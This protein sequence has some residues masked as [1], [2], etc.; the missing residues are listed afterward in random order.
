MSNKYVKLFQ[1]P[2]LDFSNIKKDDC[3]RVVICNTQ[4]K[5]ATD[6]ECSGTDVMKQPIFGSRVYINGKKHS[7]QS[8]GLPF[9]RFPQGSTPRILFENKTLFTFNIHYHGLNT[10]GSTDGVAMEDVFGLNTLLGPTTTFQFP[11]ITNNQTLLWF[12][13]HNMFVSMELIYGGIVGLLQITDKPTE[14][15]TERFEYG[16]NQLLLQTLDMDLTGDGTQTFANLV[17]DENRSCFTVVNGTSALNWYSSEPV[18]FVNPLYHKTT[19]NLVKIDI[20][21]ASMNWRVFHLGVCDEKGDIKPFYLVQNDGGLVNPSEVKMAFIPVSG[22][23]GIIIDLNHFKHKVAYLFFYNYDLTEVLGS[24]PTFPDQPNNRSITATVPDFSLENATPYPTPIPDPYQ[25]NQQSNPT[26]LDY[27]VIGTILQTEQVLDNGSIPIPQGKR[28]KLFLKIVLDDKKHHHHLSL[29]DTISDI[30]KT[31]FGRKNYEELKSLLS[32]PCVE[33]DQKVN[34]LSLLNP[35]YYYNIPQISEDTPTRNILLFPEVNINA[36]SSGNVNGT[37]ENVNG[38]NRIMTDQ[39]NSAELNI[40]W[41]LEQYEMAPNNYKPPILPTAKFRIFKTND[42]FSNTA[43]ISNDT[44]KVQIFRNQIAYGDFTQVP[45]ATVT[46][47]FPPT[48]TCQLLNVQEWVDL[49]NL[50]FQQT[51]FTIGLSQVNLGTILSCDWSFFPYAYNFL[52]QKTLYLKSAVIKTANSTNYW[53]RFL[54]RWP[55]LQFFGKP[56][57]GSTLDP[58]PNDILSQQRIK[59]QQQHLKMKNDY[60]KAMG[61]EE[62][63]QN[64]ASLTQGD[65]LPAVRSDSQYLKCDE[66]GTYG[67][68]D[69]EIQQLFPYYATSDGDNQLPIACMKRNAE[70][71]IAPLQTYIGLYDGYLNDNLNSF[72][73]R[74]RS[75]EIWLYTN[76]DCADAHSL[77]FHLT[78]GFA[79][80]LSNYNSPGLITCRRLFDPLL[81]S[82]DIYQIGPQETASFHITWPFY[83]SYDDT[84][85]PKLRCIGG[86]IHCHLLQHNDSNGMIIQYFVDHESPNSEYYGAEQNNVENAAD[87]KENNTVDEIKDTNE[88]VPACCKNRVKAAQI[89]V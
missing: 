66:V 50:T 54:G 2:L 21:N 8:F 51:T 67:T 80:P 22:R 7:K 47:I 64:K 45:L 89:V 28:M 31:I 19:R 41:A 52:Y 69:T 82:R 39:W 17:T 83:S 16:N 24:V 85:A 77:H 46:V 73:V 84:R 72:S 88:K 3:V 13:S 60:N 27:P 10:T 59:L 33:Y 9:I 71:I 44:L 70:L 58:P 42:Q 87:N 81:Y 74:L 4:H 62:E 23:I 43:M 20:Q 63:I 1:P 15:L 78:Q 5:F 48:P 30:R 68:Y 35:K 36:I 37:T 12:H 18:P 49:I 40:E 38:A 34:Y 56:M 55:L 32:Q 53:I 61:L 86:V 75:S 29:E 76:G 57:T 26:A 65:R 11:K 6:A 14:W 79:T 25:Q